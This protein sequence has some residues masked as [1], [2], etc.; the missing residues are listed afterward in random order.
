M[1][2]KKRS[3][4]TVLRF[5]SGEYSK[6]IYIEADSY[7]FYFGYSVFMKTLYI[8]NKMITFVCISLISHAPSCNQEIHRR[9][10]MLMW[11]RLI[12]VMFIYYL[13]ITTIPI[14]HVNHRLQW[15]WQGNRKLAFV[16]HLE[17]ENWLLFSSLV[18]FHCGYDN[19]IMPQKGNAQLPGVI[20]CSPYFL[21]QGPFISRL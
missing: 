9:K 4:C 1:Q 13:R 10:N 21:E 11:C 7:W 16:F 12:H 8:R 17:Q 2:L 14:S 19:V 15:V 6:Y 5:L 20:H 3:M 18:A